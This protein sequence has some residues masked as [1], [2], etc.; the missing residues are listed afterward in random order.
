MLGYGV[1]D[2]WT[3]LHLTALAGA[4]GAVGLLA[5]VVRRNTAQ[6]RALRRRFDGHAREIT[7]IAGENRAELF[8]RA[9]DL[10]GRMARME[11]SVRVLVDAT[12]AHGTPSE[13]G[14]DGTDPAPWAAGT[15]GESEAIRELG[16]L[17]GPDAYMPPL[18]GGGVSPDTMGLVVRAVRDR[19]PHLVV[20]V[21]SGA[22]TL[23]LGLALRRFRTGR[24][25]AL[26]SDLRCAGLVR[27]MVAAHGLSEIV[28]VRCP[29]D[30]EGLHGIDLLHVSRA[31]GAEG[32]DPV[33]PDLVERCAPGA[34]VIPWENRGAHGPVRE[35]LR[36][37]RPDLVFE[38]AAPES[39][40]PAR[41]A[42]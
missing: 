7:E 38:V 31:T 34:L 6:V 1:I 35:K 21:G 42:S 12:A 16:E 19:R 3:A 25:V 20:E 13:S 17:L 18:G 2:A 37:Q 26:E 22:S 28:E 32:S 29:S 23:W 4:F 5:V 27:A 40:V 9:D 30:L 39:A 8:A 36:V 24:M 33:R 11:E 10:T 41:A 15:S 14:G